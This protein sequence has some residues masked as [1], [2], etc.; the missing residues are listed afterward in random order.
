MDIPIYNDYMKQGADWGLT[1]EYLDANGNAINLTSY[2]ADCEIRD[3]ATG[4]ILATPTIAALGSSGRVALSLT[5]AQTS[6]MPA[7]MSKYDVFITAPTGSPPP[8]I[9]LVQGD[10]EISPRVTT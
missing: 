2:T 10:I 5:A 1:L 7:V 6:A 8:V 4:V 9:C 3:K